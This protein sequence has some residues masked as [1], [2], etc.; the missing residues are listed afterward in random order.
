VKKTVYIESSV[1]SYLAAR[2]T[3]DIVLA[4][5]QQITQEWWETERGKY[6]CFVSD[7]V[8]DE[9]ARGD[10]DAASRRQTMIR[11]FRKL[12]LTPVVLDLAREYKT[13]LGIPERARL[14]LFHLAIAVGN[15]MDYV[16]SW[17]FRHIANAFVRQRLQEV[18]GVLGLRTPTICTPEELVG[19]SHG[20]G[21]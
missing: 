5:Y 21:K 7:F 18:N 19:G 11:G 12:A 9:V 13:A 15:G 8:V 6:D 1:I 20:K 17:N 14:D 16:L 4:A 10:P 2:P 3:R